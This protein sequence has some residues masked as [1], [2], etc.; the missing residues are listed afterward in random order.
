MKRVIDLV[1][2]NPQVLTWAISRQY[3]G[4]LIEEPESTSASEMIDKAV[5]IFR[6]VSS[7]QLALSSVQSEEHSKEMEKKN[8]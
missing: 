4:S 2:T 6:K 7:L 1:E 3:T 8:D 5:A